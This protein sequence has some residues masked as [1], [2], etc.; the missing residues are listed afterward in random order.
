VV[1]D[2]RDGPGAVSVLDLFAHIANQEAEGV[3]RRLAASD[4]VCRFVKC[5]LSPH[6]VLAADRTTTMLRFIL[7]ATGGHLVQSDAST[8]VVSAAFTRESQRCLTFH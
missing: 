2:L 5:H 1:Q 4:Q 7:F 8:W 6:N 3:K